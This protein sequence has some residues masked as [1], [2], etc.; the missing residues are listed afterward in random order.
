MEW[1]APPASQTTLLFC[2]AAAVVSAGVHLALDVLAP[3]ALLCPVLLGPP[4]E[5]EAGDEEESE[6]EGHASL[7]AKKSSALVSYSIREDL[8]AASHASY[9]AVKSV[10]NS[11]DHMI[12][13]GFQPATTRFVRRTISPEEVA[14]AFRALRCDSELIGEGDL[15]LGS[16]DNQRFAEFV[17]CL[18]EHRG[19][20]HGLQRAVYDRQW[21]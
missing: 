17:C 10:W 21:G 18:V 12:E 13:N 15:Y 16:L 1:N 20:L 3:A 11:S 19:T 5:E 14:R 8:L 9:L 2:L 7:A 6:G 4:A